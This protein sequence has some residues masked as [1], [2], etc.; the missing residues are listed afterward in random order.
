LLV[1]SFMPGKAND[2]EGLGRGSATV[3]GLAA[4]IVFV[5]DE[6]NGVAVVVVDEEVYVRS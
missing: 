3:Q 1:K 5:V 6:E 4:I 2:P